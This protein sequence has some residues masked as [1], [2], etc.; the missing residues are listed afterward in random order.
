MA[1]N[2]ATKRI[3]PVGIQDFPDI[4]ER[5]FVYVDKTARA[6]ELITGS[7]KAFFLSRPRRFGKSLLCST[8]GAIFEG[9]RELF[10]EIA[11]RPALAMD[12]LDWEWKAHP[13]IRIDL[14]AG[15]YSG[16]VAVLDDVLQNGLENTARNYG[17]TLR[18]R[19]LPT[20][21]GNI[22]TDLH[23]RGSEKAVVIIDEYD[24]PLTN[25]LNKRDVH[26]ELRDELKA[27]YSVLKSCDAHLRF[28]FITGVSKFSHVS[29][30][31]DLNQLTD[32]TLDPR[33]ADLCGLTQ[34][35]VETNFGPEIVSVLK[36]TGRSR[37]EY[38]GELRRFY[39]G[40]RFS[41]DPLTVY[42]PLGLLKHFYSGGKYSDYRYE[43]ATPSFLIDLI[44]TQKINIL[45]LGNMQVQQS[46]FGKY[47]IDNMAAAP[48]LCQTGYLTIT[49][50]DEKWRRFTLDYPNEEVRASFAGSLVKHGLKTP[51]E[52]ADA[53]YNKLADAIDAGDVDSMLNAIKAFLAGIPYGIIDNKEKY[54]QTVVHLV[55]K[56]LG[57]NCRSEVQTADGR[58]DTLIETDESVYCFEFKL[59][60]T[61]KQALAQID[62]KEYAFPWTGSGKKVFK[63]GVSFDFE[64][65]NIGEWVTG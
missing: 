44:D 6:C 42:N 24:K 12:S 55:F 52:R 20:R 41:E 56:M 30:F 58:I 63:V 38:T 9:R 7:G 18:G 48:L 32:L 16:G 5:G 1:T 28:I 60:G 31:S 61:A 33:S 62:A 49:G 15:N 14:N 29:I 46:D 4:R 47:D 54:F 51:P 39:N 21:F 23:G 27:F 37:D 57:F 8:L 22:I 26:I 59:N 45:D 11:G 36:N 43:T 64:K 17:I 13:V 65:R 50:Y 10:G 40:Y 53:L 2:S 34:D 35:E 25:T 3:L 19:T